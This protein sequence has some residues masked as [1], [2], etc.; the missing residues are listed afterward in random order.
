MALLRLCG[1]GCHL[2]RGGEIRVRDGDEVA[3]RASCSAEWERWPWSRPRGG[4]ASPDPGDSVVVDAHQRD[5]VVD[6]GL[7][8]DAARRHLGGVRVDRVRADA[9]LL[10]QLRADVAREA[11][12]GG[13]VAVQV[14]DLAAADAEAELAARARPRLDAGPGADLV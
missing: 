4:P 10:A 6:V 13:V 12:V 5:H 3:H 14:A 7:G 8:L 11:E 1:V 9:A 2:L